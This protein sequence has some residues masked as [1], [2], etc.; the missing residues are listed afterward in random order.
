L[1]IVVLSL[2]HVVVDTDETA[3]KVLDAMLKE[4]TGRVTFM[5]LNRLKPKNAPMPNSHDI[6]PLIQKI[7]YNP[8]Y[9]KAFQQVFG[10]TCVCKELT[11]AAAYVK[12]HGINTITLDGDKVD[13]RGALTGGYHD[14]RRS[15]IE[16][17]KSVTTCR[18][19]YDGSKAKSQEVKTA[20]SRLEHDI[21]QIGGK[22]TVAM[23]QLNQ[24]KDSRDRLVEEGNTLSQKK[25]RL[26]DRTEKSEVDI[27]ELETELTE[28]RT[29]IE[30]YAAEMRTPLANAITREEE[31]LV[32]NLGREV[33]KRKKD[34]LALN[35]KKNEVRFE[36]CV[37]MV[38]IVSYIL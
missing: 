33:E 20:T 18:G 16:A 23:G 38:T 25:D 36:I 1:L 37:P 13:R 26:K 15:R 9:E 31:E 17:I 14:V 10:K 19:K 30:S 2:F 28:L 29:K 12:S 5:P 32:V 35:K 22:I 34:M 21:T 3:S 8:K 6:E 27:Q 4:K 11:M 24:I 7:Q